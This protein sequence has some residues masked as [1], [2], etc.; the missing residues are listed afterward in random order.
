MAKYRKNISLKITLKC[1]KMFI[2]NIKIYTSN[3]IYIKMQNN[4]KFKYV[5]LHFNVISICVYFT[6]KF[7]KKNG[8]NRNFDYVTITQI[9]KIKS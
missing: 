6:C 2:R 5:G 7:H 4:I 3:F 8:T 9:K 1:Q